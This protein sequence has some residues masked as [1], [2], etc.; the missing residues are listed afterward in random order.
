M[1]GAV[2]H[3]RQRAGDGADERPG[4]RGPT[5]AYWLARQ[6]F[7]PT[8]VERSEGLRSSGSPVDIR[9]PA[10]PVVDAMGLR[11]SLRAA[12][13][14]TTALRL[15][16]AS[17]RPITRVAMPSNS[18][19]GRGEIEIPRNE[20]A[21]VLVAA[22]REEAEFLFDDTITA[23]AQDEHG[24][25]VTFAR[26]APR[27]FDL[28]IGADG[29]H[30]TVRHL[31]FG[32]EDEFVRHA[33]LYVATMPLGAPADDSREVLIHNT[34]GRLVSIHPNRGRALVAFIFRGPARADFDHRDVHQHR[35]LV[36]EAYAGV[37]WRVPQLL[38]RLQETEDLYFDS[39]SQ[40]RLPTWSHGRVALLGDAA[41][42]LSLLGD[43]S[44][45]AI[46]G[47]HTLASELAASPAD[48]TAALRRYQNAHS[49]LVEPRQRRLRLSAALLAPRTRAG[50][51]ARNLAAR[52]SPTPR[53][54]P[55]N[56]QRD[57]SVAQQGVAP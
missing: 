23:L 41:S 17:G 12:A 31:V 24:V 11:P 33:G 25:D 32:P 49:A 36:T 16:A 30:S 29:L 47:A 14:E 35:R 22:A 43:G 20:L 7:R 4:Q 2:E 37:G 39:V 9:G 34:P 15:L 44:S 6:G 55:Q 26:A 5:L 46:A 21:A 54:T 1:L 13:T 56:G 40:V 57:A 50:I 45:L 19:A 18:A 38:G 28:V 48:H 8:V 51:T 3:H 42:C 53:P 52:L 10:L 27:R